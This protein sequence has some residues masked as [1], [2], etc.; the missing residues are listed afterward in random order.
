[1]YPNVCSDSSLGYC[2]SF[3]HD[4]N[5]ST[6]AWS[7]FFYWLYNFENVGNFFDSKPK[8]HY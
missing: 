1:M 5:T 8:K 2:I 6:T 3:I 7:G 4:A